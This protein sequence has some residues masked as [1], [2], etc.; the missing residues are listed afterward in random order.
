MHAL[1]G[2]LLHHDGEREA[3]TRHLREYL[4]LAPETV[5]TDW[6]RQLLHE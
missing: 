4:A 5:P 1:L 6:A 2:R 3:S